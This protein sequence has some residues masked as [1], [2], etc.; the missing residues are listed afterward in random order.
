[1]GAPGGQSSFVQYFPQ[2]FVALESLVVNT[3]ATMSL[4]TALAL[5]PWRLSLQ[6]LSWCAGLFFTLLSRAGVPPA[7]FVE[8]SK[9]RDAQGMLQAVVSWGYRC[10]AGHSRR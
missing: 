6:W 3:K 10:T 9:V 7:G 4:V 5:S 1:V 8:Q 2:R